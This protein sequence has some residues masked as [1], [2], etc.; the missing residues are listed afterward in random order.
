MSQLPPSQR[1]VVTG[2]GVVHGLGQDATTFWSSL[3]AG[4]NGIDR[5]TLFDPSPFATQMGAEVKG[6]NVEEHMDPK[7]ARRNDRYTHFGFCAAKQAYA[8]SGL[9]MNTE[10][11]DRVGVV[12]GSGIGG[13][14]TYETQLKKLHESGPRK[15]SPFTIPALIGNIC[16]GMFAIEIGAR[17][18]N[19]GVVS[20]CATGTHALGEAAEAIKR[21]DVT[22]VIAGSTENPLLEVAHIGF[23]N[24]R[25]LAGPRDGEG[26]A[27]ACRPYDVDRAGFVLG[28]GAGAFIVEDL[29]S[30]TARGATIYA[31]VVGYGSSADAHDMIQPIEGG[32]GSARSIKWALQRGKI[33][34]TEIDLINPHGTSTPVGDEREA[35]AF[36][37]AFGAR[38]AEIP[39]S[40]TKSLT[41]HL[42]GAAGAVEA[43]FTTLSLHHQVIPGT[44]HTKNVDPA[45]NLNVN[46]ETRSAEIRAAVS[47]NVGLGGHN[48][49]I[50]LRRW[51][52]K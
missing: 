23:M 19:F 21:G 10:D 38:A 18:P 43:V 8:D 41:G 44:L 31:E 11:P 17:G 22:A 1:V 36:H 33:D 24:M 28:E 12:I 39:V 9:D 3:I 35:L 42:M 26:P 20:A 2:L 40:A 16:S 30:A 7:E 25:G 45:C 27:S 52:G 4:K 49:A 48:G 46:L 34:P 5:L 13:M 32:A 50:V 14:F 15:V 47:N 37:A 6:W 29:A 51:T